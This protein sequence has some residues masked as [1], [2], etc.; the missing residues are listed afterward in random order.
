MDFLHTLLGNDIRAGLLII[1]NLMVIET[2]LSVDNAAV[3]ATMVIDLPRE[4]RSRALKYGII[5]A[6]VMRGL[7]LFL[8]AWLVK[9]WW[10]KPLGGL[11]LIY[12]TFD[13]FRG[14]GKT[15]DSG[16]GM[17]KGKSRIYRSTVGLIGTFWATVVLVEIMDL[18]FSIDNVFAVV[19]FTDHL[20]LIYIGVF[21]GILG[22]RFVAQGFVKLIEK[23]P[24]LETVA[25]VVIGLLGIKLFVSLSAHFYPNSAVTAVLDSKNTD[26]SI[27]VFTV[28]VFLLPVLSSLLLNFPKRRALRSAL[29]DTPEKE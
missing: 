19:A 22:M 2:L 13:H 24:F 23:F 10:L 15:E 12:L 28:A 26:I 18:A 25:F 29:A 8:A 17:S 7:C 6:Y 11:Y 4:Q 21:I 1:L 9:I 16:E 27:S 3:L 5:G 20:Y 14:K